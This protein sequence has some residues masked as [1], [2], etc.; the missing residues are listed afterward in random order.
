MMTIRNQARELVWAA[1]RALNAAFARVDAI[2]AVT[3]QRVLDAFQAARVSS[4]HFAPTT[5][6][7]YDDIGRDTLDTVFAQALCAEAAC[8]RPQLVNGTH[9]LY[10][11][12]AGLT[13]PGD[14]VLSITGKP[15]DTLEE[16]VGL[17]GDAPHS[18]KGCGVGFRVV[19]LLSDG[20]I[21]IEAA[22]NA[23]ASD[24]SIRVLYAQ[25][26][27]GYSWRNALSVSQLENAFLA[28]RH[29]RSDL[30]TLTDNC[31]G[32]FVEASEPVAH[33]ADVIAGSLIK[34][35]GGGLAPTGGY[36]AGKKELVAR[37][38]QR[39]TVPGMGGEVGSYAASYRPF[40]QG[41]FMAPHT[42]AQCLKGAALFAKLFE[43]LGMETLPE[44][45]AVRSDIIQ[46]IRFA[47]EKTLVRFCQSIQRAAPVD[48]FAVPEPWDM[49]GYAHQVIMAAGT[50]VQG[51]TSELSADAPIVAPYTAYLQGALSYAHA[52]IAAMLAC[53]AMLNTA[54]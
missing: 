53:D 11:S 43:L 6:Y 1:E 23:L 4:R 45:G 54:E 47:D 24:A 51:A 12:L 38:A 52:R 20:S 3:Q 48:A 18:L 26:S 32:E 29:T 35:P 37:I 14:T 39:M 31:Y 40:Y 21:D 33:G 27:R 46:A 22:K 41:L 13:K 8:V 15:Y 5:G 28:L 10:L 44:S 49:P 36:F 50:F 25:R 9:A 42:V 19:P 30:V 2:E 16:A 7:G 17:R 34:N